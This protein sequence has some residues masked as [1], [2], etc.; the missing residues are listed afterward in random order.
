[1]NGI[2]RTPMRVMALSLLL[3]G[4]G[5]EGVPDPAPEGADDAAGPTPPEAGPGAAVEAK[6]PPKPEEPEEPPP[7]GHA[8]ARV[9]ALLFTSSTGTLGFE[10]PAL[11]EDKGAPV[12]LTV[13]VVGRKDDRLEIETLVKQSGEHH[14]AGALSGLENFRLRLY[15]EED[16]LLPVL[17]DGFDQEFDDGTSLHLAKG[18]PVP[19]RT[20]VLVNGTPVRVSIPA[21]ALGRYY[22]P[23]E[24][25]H[26]DSPLATLDDM[27]GHPLRYDGEQ[28]LPEDSLYSMGP[29]L[30]YFAEAPVD[31]HMKLEVRNACLKATVL[32]S[33][34]RYAG[35]PREEPPPPVEV[36]G[37][38]ESSILGTLDSEGHFLASPYGGAFAVG[39]DDEDVW[40]GLTGSEVGEAFGVGGLGLVGTG[41]ATKTEYTVKA[42]TAVTWTDG[43][44]AGQV[45][46]DTTFES[47]PREES[48]NSC[49]GVRLTAS[50]EPTVQLCFAPGDVAEETTPGGTIGLG[51][52]GLIGKGGGGGTGYGYG[53]GAG[54]GGTGK[55]V[56]RVRAAKA[57]VKGAL[58]KDIIRRIVRAHINEVRFCYNQGLVK[59]PTLEGKVSIQ[60]TIGPTG[61]VPAAVVASETL[62]DKNVANCIAKAVKRWKFPKPSGGGNV[63][64]TYPFKLEPG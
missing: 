6:E 57:S 24:P 62:G 59:D 46:A 32:A 35:P 61:K 28:V 27:E 26:G 14:C 43:T 17:T 56:P 22:E 13:N 33:A 41:R 49:F 58:D 16:D 36:A 37:R 7:S 3:V 20:T 52:T 9:G 12:G 18:V 39:G 53:T 11:S 64:V 50:K 1:M 29:N 48:G 55:K 54:F 38:V 4:C 15:V 23:G 51:S 47:E 25:F 34:E 45:I 30:S 31:G 10:L 63:V 2:E 60:F 21:E 40:G 8:V 5:N 44:P 19:E 42:G